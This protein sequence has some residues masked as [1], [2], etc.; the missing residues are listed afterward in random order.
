V[1]ITRVVLLLEAV[2][3]TSNNVPEATDAA[4]ALVY[5]VDMQL[6][7]LCQRLPVDVVSTG[8]ADAGSQFHVAVL[9]WFTLC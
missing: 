9:H 2:N 5:G 1:G 7:N 4:Q 8:L 3:P 6:F